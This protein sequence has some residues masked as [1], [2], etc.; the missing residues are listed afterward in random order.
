MIGAAGAAT[1]GARS[2]TPGYSSGKLMMEKYKEFRK[3]LNGKK[4]PKT[5]GPS[6]L[7]QEWRQPG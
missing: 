2:P 4:S 7:P 3:K 1:S 5:V 6:W